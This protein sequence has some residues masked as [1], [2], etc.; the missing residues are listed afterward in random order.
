MRIVGTLNPR[1]STIAMAAAALLMFSPPAFCGE[2]DRAP[3]EV[4]DCVKGA[5]CSMVFEQDPG[6]PDKLSVGFSYVIDRHA[7]PT[8]I[9]VTA[10]EEI[11]FITYAKLPWEIVRTRGIDVVS[12]EHEPELTYYAQPGDSFVILTPDDENRP[13][14]FEVQI[15]ATPVDQSR[16]H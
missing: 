1:R 7:K 2:S 6:N 15:V 5:A 13:W 4:I 16:K 12:R 8:V 10:G 9:K 3:G 11:D 14:V